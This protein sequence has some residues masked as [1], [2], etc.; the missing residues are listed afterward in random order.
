MNKGVISHPYTPDLPLGRLC[1]TVL[2]LPLIYLLIAN[3]AGLVR[4]FAI[5]SDA[6]LGVFDFFIGQRRKRNGGN[7]MDGNSFAPN[8]APLVSDVNKFDWISL[9]EE[10]A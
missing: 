5:G 7:S 6:G 8:I 4:Y 10:K 9:D 3:F 1:S 2:R